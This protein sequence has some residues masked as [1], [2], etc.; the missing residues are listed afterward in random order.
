MFSFTY[1]DLKVIRNPLFEV[2]RQKQVQ[3]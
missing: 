2:T 1:R 3:N